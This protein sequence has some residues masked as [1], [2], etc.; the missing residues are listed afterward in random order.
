ML[1]LIIPPI[2]VI[3]SLLGIIVFLVKRADRV[4]GMAEKNRKISEDFSGELSLDNGQALG[5]RE[6]L[7][8]GFK[9]RMLII[10]EKMTKRFR[11][12]FLRLENVF[13]SWG[14]SLRERRKRKPKE[15]SGVNGSEQPKE[16]S[17]ADIIERVNNY[18]KE[19]IVLNERQTEK[20]FF[21]RG[22]LSEEKIVR[23]MVSDKVSE[24]A[25]K[26]VQM[27]NHLEKILIERI[28]ANPKDT[29]AYERLGEYYFEIGNWEHSKECYKQVMKLSP[30]NIG[31]RS[32]MRKLE[33]MLGG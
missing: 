29:E 1:Y 14:N 31:V 19:K 30:R 26:R 8:E 21:E 20:E 4:V 11:V 15:I 16:T 33:R 17:Q 3:L 22:S 25:T 32:R 7:V 5:G 2:L 28:A 6:I 23:P 27:K 10:L 12:I 24:P 9:H 18:Q 13:T